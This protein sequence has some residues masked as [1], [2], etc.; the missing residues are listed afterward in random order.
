MHADGDVYEGEW[1]N[2]K[3]EGHGTYSHANGAFYEG[4]WLDDKQHG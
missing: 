4:S 2:D 3:A 1:V